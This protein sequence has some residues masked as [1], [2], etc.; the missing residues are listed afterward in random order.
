MTP[1]DLAVIVS[2]LDAQDELLHEIRAHVRETNGRVKTL[3]LWRA[4]QEARAEVL[5]KQQAARADERSWWRRTLIHAAVS[6]PPAVATGVL[7]A[8][9]T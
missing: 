5:A 9:L 3:E 8:A 2:R 4:A 7:V 6:I 1:T